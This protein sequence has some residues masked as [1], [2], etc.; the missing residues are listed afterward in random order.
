MCAGL[1]ER[2]WE[3]QVCELGKEVQAGGT[4]LLGTCWVRS[5]VRTL[6]ED[7]AI[8]ERPAERGEKQTRA[9]RG[10]EVW[11]V[12]VGGTGSPQGKGEEALGGRM[13][14]K[15]WPSGLGGAHRP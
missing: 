11:R 2:A 13:S 10:L 14:G 8:G 4:A 5:M 12:L 6:A 3:A 15:A 9:P 1:L 7:G